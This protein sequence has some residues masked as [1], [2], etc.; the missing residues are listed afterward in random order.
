M[1]NMKQIRYM[2]TSLVALLMWSCSAEDVSVNTQP[3]GVVDNGDGTLTLTVSLDVPGMEIASSR[4]MGDTPG[5]AD[6]KLYL[7]EFNLNGH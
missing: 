7:L 2:I 5:Y 3:S 1:E 6:L 4:V